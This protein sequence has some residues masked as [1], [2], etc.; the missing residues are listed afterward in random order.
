MD[1]LATY[2]FIPYFIVT[3]A[4]MGRP[5][6]AS[7]KVMWPLTHWPVEIYNKLGSGQTLSLHCKSEEDD[8][9]NQLLQGGQKFSWRLKENFFSTTLFWC[10]FRTS[11]DKHVAMEVFWR[12]TK[13]NWLAY[14]CNYENC[15]WF[16][17]DDGVYLVNTPKNSTD[18]VRRWE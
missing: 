10:N 14:H 3:I 7:S 17:Q 5:C 15:I 18:L 12:E 4:M 1:H 16:A 8:L 13:G 6:W 11:T 2:C 9:G